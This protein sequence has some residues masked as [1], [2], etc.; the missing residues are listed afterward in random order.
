MCKPF[1]LHHNKHGCITWC[2]E[3]NHI[4]IAFGTVVF[5]MD[6]AR[7]YAFRQIL[8]TDMRQ[9]IFSQTCRNKTL[10]YHTDSRH[11]NIVLS[12]RE[13]IQLLSLLNYSALMYEALF[14]LHHPG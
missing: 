6:P 3:C 10:A 2:P 1:T 4:N 12:Y 5:A 8:N 14:I 11:V 9:C 13:L 7:F